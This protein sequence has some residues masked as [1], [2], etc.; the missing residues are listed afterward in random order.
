MGDKQ[1]ETG[2]CECQQHSEVVEHRHT[3]TRRCIEHAKLLTINTVPPCDHPMQVLIPPPMSVPSPLK[4][5]WMWNS[6]ST[7]DA[8][9]AQRKTLTAT[10]PRRAWRVVLARKAS[11]GAHIQEEC[12]AGQCH[13]CKCPQ[14]QEP[15]LHPKPHMCRDWSAAPS[16]PPP[17]LLNDNHTTSHAH[18]IHGV[19]YIVAQL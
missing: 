4:E 8:L 2:E 1:K 6:H 9:N 11:G 10:K 14:L 3:R 13:D 19:M 18:A 7:L 17:P 16:L 5:S 12:V 15:R